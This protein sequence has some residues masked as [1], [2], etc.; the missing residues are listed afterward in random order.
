MAILAKTFSLAP[1]RATLWACFLAINTRFYRESSRTVE[2]LPCISL[3]SRHFKI[4]IFATDIDSDAINF[5][6]AG[7]YPK[8]LSQIYH[9]SY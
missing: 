2:A 5:A 1:C 6:R 7:V 9:M 3:P 4:Q 8:V